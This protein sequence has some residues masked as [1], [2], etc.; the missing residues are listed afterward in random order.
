VQWLIVAALEQILLLL[1]GCAAALL[2]CSRAAAGIETWSTLV[3][4]NEPLETCRDLEV[5][6]PLHG[7]CKLA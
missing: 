1:E 2:Q 6:N 5:L 4:A 3:R 7:W